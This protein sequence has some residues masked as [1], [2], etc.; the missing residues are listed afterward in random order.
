LILIARQR[1]WP[2]NGI[3][4]RGT[5]WITRRLEQIQTELDAM[6]LDMSA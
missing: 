3:W 1:G 4:R 2:E 6:R 5:A